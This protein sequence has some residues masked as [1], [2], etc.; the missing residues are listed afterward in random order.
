VNVDCFQELEVGREYEVVA[1]ETWGDGIR[2]Y[3]EAIDGVWCP[4]PN[5][6]DMFELTE[7]T[8][9]QGWSVRMGFVGTDPTIKRMSFT[10]WTEN[11]AF[12]EMLMWN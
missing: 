10:A 11:D 8:V 6:A 1:I 2:I 5:P 9:P 12:Y 7:K 4:S 3:I